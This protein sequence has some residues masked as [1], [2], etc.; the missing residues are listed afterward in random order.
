MNTEEKFVVPS[1]Q[2]EENP[3]GYLLKVALPG[4]GKGDIELHIEG[5]TLVLKAHSN[6]FQP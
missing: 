1:T 2:F 4:I 3:E 6:I 5:K